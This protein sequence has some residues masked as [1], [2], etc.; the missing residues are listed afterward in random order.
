MDTVFYWAANILFAWTISALVCTVLSAA[1]AGQLDL[2]SREHDAD[3]HRHA[4]RGLKFGGVL[5]AALYGGPA[6]AYY[7]GEGVTIALAA[8]LLGYTAVRHVQR[9]QRRTP[10]PQWTEDQL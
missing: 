9:R 7:L 5:V 3:L 10:A 2:H 6:L 4:R 1:L 8:G